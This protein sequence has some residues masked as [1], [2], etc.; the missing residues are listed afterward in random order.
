MA[1]RLHKAHTSFSLQEEVTR[2]MEREKRS[3]EE[4][5]AQFRSNLQAAEAESRELQVCK[6]RNK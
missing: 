1:E 5:V 3:L 6:R 4:E 2:H